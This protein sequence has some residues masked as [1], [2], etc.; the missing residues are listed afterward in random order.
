MKGICSYIHET[1]WIPEVYCVAAILYL[2]F[3]AHVM[4]FPKISAL[5]FYI[6]TLRS[7]CSVPN[8]AV[9]C[10]CLTLCFPST[11]LRYFLNDFE[12]VTVAPGITFV[13]HSTYVD[14]LIV[15]S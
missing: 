14:I 15:R 3:M 1:I 11:L 9:C 13:L 12:L 10:S 4:L 7:K 6:S 5:Y 2:Q 8:M